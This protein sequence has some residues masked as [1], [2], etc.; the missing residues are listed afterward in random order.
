MPPNLLATA[1]WSVLGTLLSSTQTLDL[2]PDH[3][4]LDYSGPETL[5]IASNPYDGCYIYICFCSLPS[6]NS[7]NSAIANYRATGIKSCSFHFIQVQCQLMNAPLSYG[8]DIK[9]N[10]HTNRQIDLAYLISI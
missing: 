10:A 7:N 2:E 5:Y 4:N 9:F 8:I 3:T 1:C 6:N